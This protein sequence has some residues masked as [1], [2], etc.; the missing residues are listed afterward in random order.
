MD[1]LIASLVSMRLH[2]SLCILHPSCIALVL[3][4]YFFSIQ[5]P[6]V[7]TAHSSAPMDVIYEEPETGTN[8]LSMPDEVQADA[9]IHN[10]VSSSSWLRNRAFGVK[11]SHSGKALI[12]W[13]M[14]YAMLIHDIASAISVSISA[15]G[16]P[17]SLLCDRPSATP[18][19]QVAPISGHYQPATA[20]H[21]L[22]LYIV[23]G[24]ERMNGDWT[25]DELARGRRLV[26]FRKVGM[27]GCCVTIAVESTPFSVKSYQHTYMNCVAAFGG[28]Y[29]TNTNVIQLFSHLL[30][31]ELSRNEQA[32][33]RR[34]LDYFQHFTVSD[35]DDPAYKG[36][37]KM[38]EWPR[39]CHRAA[40]FKLFSWHLLPEALARVAAR[41]V[42]SRDCWAMWSAADDD[43]ECSCGTRIKS[44]HNVCRDLI[45][46]ID[47]FNPA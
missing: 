33:I 14:L 35:K 20:S 37:T 15:P 18:D 8:P 44:L 7:R 46:S 16:S 41:Y 12:S 26:L 24:L 11:A 2:H 13:Q 29:F 25:S 5:H 38:T 1:T 31:R 40:P 42:S 17:G 23:G 45:G 6:V 9:R 21:R 28:H 22:H 27:N 39:P 3:D 43:G 10:E 4:G 36:I 47:P 30:D 19:T 34:D 32:Q